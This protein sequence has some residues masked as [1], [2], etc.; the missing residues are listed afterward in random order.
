ME[1]GIITNL[2]G[3]NVVLPYSIYNA[4]GAEVNMI[5]EIWKP[6]KGYE[7]YYSVSN[8]GNVK[9]DRRNK[10]LSPKTDKDGYFEYCF[11]VNEER[12]YFRGHRLVAAAFI[13]NPKDYLIINHKDGNKQNNTVG[14]LEWCDVFYNTIH[15]NRRNTD[16]RILSS[17]TKTDFIEMVRLYR[18][19]RYSFQDLIVH[20]NLDVS[21][22]QVSE[23]LKGR[24]FSSYTGLTEDIRRCKT[25]FYSYT[26]SQVNDVLAL[27]FTDKL[28][29]NTIA[30]MTNLNYTYVY[31]VV[32]RI[33]RT[34]LYDNFMEEHEENSR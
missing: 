23:V 4:E 30:S 33:V 22:D 16:K 14:N 12:R 20:F 28:D 13:D 21:R 27:Y 15:G 25:E 9:S 34:K 32:K 3:F 8:T 18:D 17:L 10:L 1:Y 11:C 2:C 6:I 24:R 7:G 29:V 5:K 31:K 19:E 26:D